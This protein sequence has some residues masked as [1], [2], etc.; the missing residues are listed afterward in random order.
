M[1]A[2]SNLNYEITEGDRKRKIIDIQAYSFKDSIINV[3]SGPSGSGK[4]TL[5]YALG[6]ILNITSG[7]VE[8]NGTSLYDLDRVRR[9]H[10]R[11][12]NI[13]MVYQNYNLFSFMTVE[14]NI[15]V[16]Y[17]IKGIKVDSQVKKNVSEYLNIMNLGKI[18][19]KSINALSGGEQQRV[20]IIR[21]IIRKPS[22]ILC[23]E[24]TASLD[25][26]NTIIFME[27][28]NTLN[29]INRTT[30]IIATH[31]EKVMKYA[32][33]RVNMIDGKIMLKD[34]LQ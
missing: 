18:H 23:D 22:V 33:N 34:K 15:L 31:D 17:F 12:D 19:N 30:V 14:E 20:A 16:P 29:K 9:D 13:S 21:A 4:T 32:E 2:I 25:S 7:R 26:E 28:L 10:F 3:V 11:M 5:L 6:G 27:N 24:P 8:I 1:I